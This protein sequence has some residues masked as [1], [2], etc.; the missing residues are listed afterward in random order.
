MHRRPTQADVARLA[1]VS[2]STVGFALSDRYDIAIPE[3]TRQ[4]VKRAALEINYRPNLAA[5]ALNSGRMNAVTIAFPGSIHSYYARVLEMFEYHSNLHGYHLIA[6]TIGSLDSHNSGLDFATLLHGPSDAVMLVDAFGHYLPNVHEILSGPK[7][8]I[9]M[10]ITEIDGIDSIVI[11][12]MAGADAACRHLI[13]G[14]ARR[15]MYFGANMPQDDIPAYIEKCLTSDDA[16]P[17]CIAFCRAARAAGIPIH[18][19]GGYLSDRSATIDTLEA[20]IAAHGCPDAIF[21]HNDILAIRVHGVLRRMGYQIPRD[22][23]LIGCDGIEACEDMEPPLST[24]QQPVREMCAAAWEFLQ[25]RLAEPDRPRQ[26]MRIPA[27]FL[28]RASS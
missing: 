23:R 12:L 18:M 25:A 28:P 24:I 19:V 5:R 27:R 15:M 4:R 2:K 26:Y 16:D 20:Y 14:G 6:S 10:G 21:C 1:G 11:D 7:P 3:T 22:V 9:S 8:V 13:E 17:R